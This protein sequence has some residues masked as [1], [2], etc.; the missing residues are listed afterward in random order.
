[1]TAPAVKLAL[2]RARRSGAQFRAA[3]RG[4]AVPRGQAQSHGAGR[5]V[6][7]RTLRSMARLRLADSRILAPPRLRPALARLCDAHSG[8]RAVARARRG[9]HRPNARTGTGPARTGS[10]RPWLSG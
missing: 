3:V 10:G 5:R 1:R 2:A 6:R 8:R 9:N 4:D 7:A